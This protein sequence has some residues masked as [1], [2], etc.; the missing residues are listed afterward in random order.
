MKERSIFRVI[1]SRIIFILLVLLILFSCAALIS[2]FNTGAE[3]V[4][5]RSLDLD[6]DENHQPIIQWNLDAM[7]LGSETLSSH[8][9]K[10]IEKAYKA[11]W[12]TLNQVI[13]R[14]ITNNLSDYFGD[15]LVEEIVNLIDLQGAVHFE[16]VDLQHEIKAY[17]FSLDKQ[18]FAFKDRNVK[19]I[20]KR[21]E[22]N[23][24]AYFWES[25]YNYEV[26]MGLEDG[27]WKIIR[28]KK[29]G[30]IQEADSI[31]TTKQVACEKIKGINYYPLENPWKDF[32]RNYNEE[33][34]EK[35]LAEIRQSG[36]NS[37]RVFLPTD[38]SVDS[39]EFA[40]MLIRFKTFLDQAASHELSVIPCLFDFPAEFGLS[41]YPKALNQIVEIARTFNNHPALLMW[42]IKNEPDK[43]YPI[44]QEEQVKNWLR[45][46]IKTLRQNSDKAVTIGWSSEDYVT[47]LIN[48]VDI[49]SFHHYKDPTLIGALVDE[50]R[51][52]YPDKQIL[53]SEFG[54]SSNKNFPYLLGYS[55]EDQSN[56]F[57]SVLPILQEKEVGFYVWTWHDFAEIPKDVFGSKPWILHKQKHFGLKSLDGMSKLSLTSF[58]EL[59]KS[60]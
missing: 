7:A 41:S 53:L 33:V 2:Y 18:L 14:K 28:M 54:R 20:N 13:E 26:I 19:I 47:D 4:A 34:I 57:R 48:E 6:L 32:F 11:A 42:D 58:K 51:L 9:Q 27:K 49:I 56:Y 24:P 17:L 37:L 21:K 16:Q 15:T 35:D 5:N 60:K 40:D 36:F 1:I 39:L 12:F 10:Q 23:E 3:L 44:H 45:F 38:G 30:E 52:Q 31:K 55:E 59:S 50:I 22:G 8:D 43:D 25:S 29:I 46:A